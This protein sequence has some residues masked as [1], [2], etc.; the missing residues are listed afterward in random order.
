MD[1]TFFRSLL[2][3]GMLI[4][5]LWIVKFYET[6]FAS[7]LYEYGILP[8]EIIGLRGILFSPFIHGDFNHLISNSVPCFI[9]MIL[10]FNTYD[11][12][13]FPI[14]LFI[15]IFGGFLVWAIAPAGASHIGISGIIYGIAFFLISAGLF[16]KDRR[17]FGISAVVLFLYGGMIQGFLPQDGV[18]WQGH[19]F[20]AITGAVAAFFLRKYRLDE[21]DHRFEKKEVEKP[22][23]LN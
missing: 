11:K 8:K 10:I 13:A 6:L 19:L 16:R 3:T 1:K 9:L 14:I 18:S 4:S 21:D 20:G 7:P 22:F 2:F 17:S 23:F 5:I 12:I 15:H